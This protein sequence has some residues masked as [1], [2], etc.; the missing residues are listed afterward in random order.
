M[1]LFWLKMHQN[2]LA[3]WRCRALGGMGAHSAPPDLL[4]GFTCKEAALWQGAERR[5]GTESGKAGREKE[6]REG[7]KEG[8][9]RRKVELN[10]TGSRQLASY[11]GR[12]RN[13]ANSGAVRQNPEISGEICN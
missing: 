12:K 2:R 10:A 11:G 9:G 3:A 5:K 4:A 6:R 1:C 8:R 13:R 7:S